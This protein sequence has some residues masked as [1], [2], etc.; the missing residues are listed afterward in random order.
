MAAFAE[1]RYFGWEKILPAQEFPIKG[2]SLNSEQ[3]LGKPSH[4]RQSKARCGPAALKIVMGYFGTDVS[5]AR[6]R[7]RAA[8]V[9]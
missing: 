4:S 7:P 5:E 9:A 2:R 6:V 8:S 3:V 1:G